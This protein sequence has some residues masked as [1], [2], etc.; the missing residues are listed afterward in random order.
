MTLIRNLYIG[1]IPD[2]CALI[3][4]RARIC[5]FG[6]VYT[7]ANGREKSVVPQEI[8][9]RRVIDVYIRKVGIVFDVGTC[10]CLCSAV[11]CFSGI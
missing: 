4:E 3:V 10:E 1:K 11:R 2:L 7:G 6:G 5:V 9:V 8:E